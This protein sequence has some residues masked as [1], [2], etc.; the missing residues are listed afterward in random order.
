MVKDIFIRDLKECSDVWET[1]IFQH[2]IVVEFEDPTEAKINLINTLIVDVFTHE[3]FKEN[4]IH[5]TPIDLD[6][7]QTCWLNDSCLRV[8]IAKRSTKKQ[9]QKV[10][11]DNEEYKILTDNFRIER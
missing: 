8:W 4:G 1:E 5:I 7:N 9:I 11:D 2:C 6:I 10:L 3:A